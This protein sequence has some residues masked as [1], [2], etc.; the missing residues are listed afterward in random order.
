MNKFIILLRRLSLSVVPVAVMACFMFGSLWLLSA[1]TENSGTFGRLHV[2]LVVVNVIGLIVL[3][4]LIGIDVIRLVRQYR[5][6]VTGSKLTARLVGIFVVMAIV[7]VS[8]VFYFSLGFL[9][10]GIDS[11]FDVR[12]ERAMDDAL[13]L[14]RS[15][16]DMRMRDLLK[17]TRTMSAA[18]QNV[19][20]ALALFT[21]NDLRY[22]SN[23]SELTL[24]TETGTVI[25]SS[26]SDPTAI[27]PKQPGDDVLS[28]LREEE[29]YVG[30]APIDQMGLHVRVAIR[31]QFA[32]SPESRVLFA[33][34]PL[35]ERISILADS[36]QSAFA[37]YKELVY[38][39]GPL[40]QSF[41]FTLMLVVLVTMLSAVWVA[42][43]FAQR[44]VAPIRVL[45]VGTRAVASGNY[46]KKLPIMR[47]DELGELVESFVDMTEKVSSAQEEARRSQHQAERERTYLGAVL[48]RL[49]S[50]VITL[51][52]NK[53]IRA[54][55][56]AASQVLGVD[57]EPVRGKTLEELE[58]YSPEIQAFVHTLVSHVNDSHDE[59]REEVMLVGA[60]G[61]KI[62]MCQGSSLPDL[63]GMPA[64]SVVVFDDVTAL[65]QAQ[66]DAAWGEVARRLA[67]EIKNPLTPIQ[68]SAERLRHKYLDKMAA[69]DAEVLDRS[70]HTIVQ[71]VQALKEMV[72][73]FSDYARAPKLQLQ[74]LVLQTVIDE[75]LDLYRGEGQSV[76]LVFDAD[77]SVPAVEADPGR[78][79]QL[80]HNLIRNALESLAGQVDAAI[81]V[82]L[83][84][85]ISEDKHF[86]ELQ[87]V[88][89]GPGIEENMLDK[90]FEPYATNKSKGSGLGLAV[91]KRIVEEHSGILFAEN[92]PDGGA[93]FVVRL[94]ALEYSVGSTKAVARNVGAG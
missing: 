14:S 26:S 16:L 52:N 15:S 64:G 90:L 75:V 19:P 91:V 27:I 76:K 12:I 57:L 8:I 79:R 67:H 50:G 34:F 47:G 6:M 18:L 61:K 62:L 20:D 68:L 43:F 46:N 1:A 42:F 21:L 22:Q 60:S 32:D 33:L 59:W 41:S 58:A 70:T 81:I 7:P 86:V 74:P 4:G 71:Q 45:A 10:K 9:Q 66:R 2:V 11:W 36:V 24:V 48:G 85:V 88:D 40:K 63:M 87:V 84:S 23:A 51:D 28:R 39:R 53:R 35:D 30:L 69:E 38:L 83:S 54:V 37:K 94:P 25:A 93:R 55:N 17:Q 80:L 82:S 3:V 92:R 89:N 29:S 78:F 5:R 77:E 73:A 49:S 72:Q 31:S 65:I 13:D 44:L 56:A